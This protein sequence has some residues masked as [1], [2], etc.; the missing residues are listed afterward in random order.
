MSKD[1]DED[2]PDDADS[3]DPDQSQEAY[4]NRKNPTAKDYETNNS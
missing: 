4:E 1:Q 3:A 2:S